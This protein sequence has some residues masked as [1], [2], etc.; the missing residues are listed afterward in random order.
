MPLH[1]PYAFMGWRGTTL[2]LFCNDI[3]AIKVH[4]FR[5]PPG[6]TGVLISPYPDP[7]E[8]TIERSLFFVRRGVHRCRGD[9]V[10]RKTF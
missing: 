6:C 7:T 9:L 8:K 5:L 10:G 2:P 3:P 1:P 4:L